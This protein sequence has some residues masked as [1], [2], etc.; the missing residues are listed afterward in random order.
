MG[1]ALMRRLW[2]VRI[3]AD[4]RDYYEVL[5]VSKGASGEEIKKAFRK[6]SKKYHPDLHPGD[7]E[8]EEKFKEVNEAYQVLSDDEKR[9]RY[10]Q[11]G[12][13]GVD[14]N[15][16]GFGGGGFG[17]AGGF[18]FGDIGDIFG[19]LFGGGFGGGRARRNGPRRGSDRSQYI[20]L[21]FEE[22]AFGCKKKINITKNEACSDCGGTGA[23][24][25]TQ[26]ET[27]PQC[28]GTGQVQQRRQTM[29]GFSNV[30]TECPRCHGKGKIIK[31]P[32]T[33]CRGTG[34]VRRNKTIE[35]NIP[36][37]IDDEQV[38]RIGG[39]GNAGENGGPNGDLQLVIRVKPHDIFKRDGYDVN[40]VFPITFVQA[41]LGA[42]LKVP[43]IHGIV[44]YDI[45]EG[46]QTNTRFRLKGKGIPILNGRGNGDEYVTVTVEVPKNL[47]AKQKELL[48]EFDE[49]KNY[50]KKKSFMDKMRDAFK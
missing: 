36:A 9:R 7:K 2:K 48:R 13:A 40:V 45:P 1:T 47:S 14:G 22:A 5:G 49:D 12:H 24:K 38:M 17:G 33:S 35:V 44:E 11:F 25:G 18:D 41:A 29:F 21:T 10:D 34:R 37:G 16:G 28:N 6:M 19:D 8:A 4:K 15:A 39:A 31:E 32:C 30:I 20:T 42:T 27:C 50:T 3:L 26:P 23:K 43:T 46:T